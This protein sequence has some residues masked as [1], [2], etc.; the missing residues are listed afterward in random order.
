[1]HEMQGMFPAICPDQRT[2][3][4]HSAKMLWAIQTVPL[5]S[6]LRGWQ[7]SP[8]LVI[9]HC[10]GTETHSSCQV[11]RTQ[12]FFQSLPSRTARY[13]SLHRITATAQNSQF[14]HH[15]NTIEITRLQANRNHY[16]GVR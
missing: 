9:A 15:C 1:M 11:G 16:V 7:E 10:L 5:R 2:C 14:L 6:S 12:N 3:R 8:A 13:L 4:I